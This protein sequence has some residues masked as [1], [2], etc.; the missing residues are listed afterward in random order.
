M[1]VYPLPFGWTHHSVE[2][3]TP[4]Q[5]G[6]WLRTH[7]ER[8]V[9]SLSRFMDSVHPQDRNPA[10]HVLRQDAMRLLTLWQVAFSRGELESL[11]D[12]ILPL[13]ARLAPFL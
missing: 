6:S 9:G 8:V 13:E 10:R 4:E 5:Y 11:K 12:K 3:L 1:H 7:R 2:P